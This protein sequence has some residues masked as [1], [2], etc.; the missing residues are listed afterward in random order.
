MK[1][2]GLLGFCKLTG[3]DNLLQGTILY[4][5]ERKYSTSP[6]FSAITQKT[7]FISLLSLPVLEASWS[8]EPA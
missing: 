5:Q 1:K 7:P 4:W 8:P 6:S 2:L 3:I